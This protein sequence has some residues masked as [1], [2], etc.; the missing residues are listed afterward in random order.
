M[1]RKRKDPGGRRDGSENRRE[2]TVYVCGDEVEEKEVYAINEGTRLAVEE[3]EEAP[4][5]GLQCRLG[6]ERSKILIVSWD[7]VDLRLEVWRQ[8]VLKK[9]WPCS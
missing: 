2:G 6:L 3:R 9:M 1:V 5:L 8:C 7:A 4:K